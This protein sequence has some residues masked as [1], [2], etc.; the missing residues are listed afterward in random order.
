MEKPVPIPQ[1]VWDILTTD[2]LVCG[3][4]EG[5]HI[6]P[7]DVPLSWFSASAIHLS[8]SEKVD[9]VVMGE[10]P[11]RGANIIPFWVFRATADGYKLVLEASVHDLIV[12]NNRSHGY[13]DIEMSG[14]TALRYTS[15]LFRFDGEQYKRLRVRSEEMK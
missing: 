3:K 13:R 11:L 10:G 2:E 6:S 5:E 4:R 1:G 12:K 7:K 9:F 14:E 8:N 15:V